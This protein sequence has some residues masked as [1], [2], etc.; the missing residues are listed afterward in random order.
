MEEI[1]FKRVDINGDGF[2][3]EEDRKISESCLMNYAQ[4]QN[5]DKKVV[6]ANKA[7]TESYTNTFGTG[8]DRVS[9]ED[10]LKKVAEIAVADQ[11]RIKRGAEPLLPKTTGTFFDMMD[12]DKDGFVS[13]EDFKLGYVAT[14]WDAVG[15]E[16]AFRAIDKDNSGRVG[17]EDMMKTA[18]EFWYKI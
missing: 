18:H 15:A 3:S 11:E 16:H 10:W 13:L 1:A 9:K 8:S 14:G 7:A 17:L 6:E 2:I 4:E 5:V 12:S